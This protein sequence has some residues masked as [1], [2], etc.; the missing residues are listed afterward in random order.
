MKTEKKNLFGAQAVTLKN[1]KG[2]EVTL[3]ALG[4]GIVSVKLPDSAGTLRELTRLP[5]SGYGKDYHG[6]TIGRT[7]GRI[8]NAEF[9]IDGRIAKLQK[10]NFGVDNL[11]GGATGFH[12]K[13]YAMAVNGGKEYTDVVFKAKSP[14]GEG[15][16]FGAVDIT[17][18]YRVYENENR[19]AIMFDCVPDSKLLLNLTNHVYWNMS[20]DLRDPHTEQLVQ[21]NASRV[22]MLDERLIVREIAEVPEQFDFRS[23]KKPG[24]HIEDEIVQR[25]THGYDHPFFLDGRGLDKVASTMYS[26]KSGIK[27]SVRTTYT[28]VVVYGDNFGGY[29]SMCFE[30]QYHPDGIHACPDDCGVCTPEKPY[31]ETTEYFFEVD[32]K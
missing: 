8:E 1:A 17:V 12:S 9:S 16:Y 3:S 23:P 7:S 5:D 2:L 30:C 22:G 29:K 31:K 6:L 10:N 19:F 4:A 25:H 18:T 28:C 15:G 21:I 14:D 13:T 32:K 27:L 11:H 26:A 24:L 20:G